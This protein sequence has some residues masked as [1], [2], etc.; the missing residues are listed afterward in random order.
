MMAGGCTLMSPAARR[1][2]SGGGMKG[3]GGGGQHTTKMLHLG[4]NEAGQ[5][6]VHSTEKPMRL[7]E[8]GGGKG[9]R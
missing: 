3:Q 9:P 5:Q 2:G 1:V 7:A 6:Q 8:E 4:L